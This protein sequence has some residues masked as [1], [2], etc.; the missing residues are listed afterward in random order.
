MFHI[1]IIYDDDH[2][3]FFRVDKLESELMNLAKKPK[4]PSLNFHVSENLTPLLL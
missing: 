4:T 2:L 1:I 3:C